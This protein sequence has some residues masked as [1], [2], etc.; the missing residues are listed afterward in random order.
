[1]NNL[2]LL[3]EWIITLIVHLHPDYVLYQWGLCSANQLIN[4]MHACM[5]VM[6]QRIVE[7]IKLLEQN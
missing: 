7:L 1:M 6:Y 2:S 4:V 3:Q 5:Q